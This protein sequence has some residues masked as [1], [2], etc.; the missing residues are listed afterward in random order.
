MS[1]KKSDSN[2]KANPGWTEDQH[3]ADFFKEYIE[4]DIYRPDADENL[5]TFITYRS[6][7]TIYI[8]MQQAQNRIKDL[9]EKL[10]VISDNM[11]HVDQG[12]VQLMNILVMQ[13][14]INKRIRFHARL[15][16]VVAIGLLL[17]LGYTAFNI[18]FN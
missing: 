10:S 14:I 2:D 8:N 7:Y 6:L 12:M 15:L 3:F 9:D 17:I 4:E 1:K 11:I 13:E 18:F 16:L 5:K